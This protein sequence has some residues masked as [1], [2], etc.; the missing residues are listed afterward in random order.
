MAHFEPLQMDWDAERG[1]SAR[2]APDRRR[3]VVL[4]LIEAPAIAAGLMALAFLAVV[5]AAVLGAPQ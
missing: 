2:R 1:A 5:A 3:A 4:A